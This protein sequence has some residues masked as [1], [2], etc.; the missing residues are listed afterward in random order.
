MN[1]AT[2]KKPAKKARSAGGIVLG[3]VLMGCF[4]CELLVYTWC[5]VQYTRVGYEISRAREE[6]A[7]LMTVQKE[8]QVELA[9]L[10][11]PERLAG[12]AETSMGLRM[13]SS[14]QM[15]VVE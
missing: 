15:M 8:L 13:P 7:R 14:R 5:R 3:F 2:S 11:S 1:R 4:I 6:Q 9:R 12:I 10:S